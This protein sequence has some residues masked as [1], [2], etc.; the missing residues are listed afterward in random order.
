MDKITDAVE[1]KP[2]D[3]IQSDD[4]Y[5]SS[6]GVRTILSERLHGCKVKDINYQDAP[7]KFYRPIKQ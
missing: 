5:I 2:G 1:L 4:F 3:I 7:I 6:N